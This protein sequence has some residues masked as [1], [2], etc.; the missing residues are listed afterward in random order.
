MSLTIGVDVGGTKI[1][2]GVVTEDGTLLEEQRRDTPA[3]D[4]PATEEAIAD[5]VRDLCSRHTAEAV[6]IAAAG[7]VDAERSSVLFAPNLAWRDEPLREAV[8]GLTDLP[9]VVE[10]D[11]NAAA[12]GEF[13]FGAAADVE[14]SLMVAL[15]TGIGGAI[16]IDGDLFR[17]T[18][19]VAGEFGHMRVVPDG[20]LCG[21][22]NHGCW[23]QYASGKAMTRAAREA[24]AEGLPQ[25]AELIARAGGDPDKITGQLIMEAARD[26][27]GFAL[28]AFG[29]L[30]RWLGEGLADLAA[31]F[32][33]GVIVL[34]GGVSEAGNL[35]LE[36]TR[37]A[38][39]RQLPGRGHRPEAELRLAQLGNKAGMVGVADL[40]RHRP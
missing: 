22:G 38:F 17:G 11:A 36:P 13:R 14:D 9:V 20:H 24:A 40:A 3:L 12:W 28:A 23:E 1:A 16:V 21:C 8:E 5:A 4:A 29:T 39:L 32:D 6:G 34:G 35:L 37:A 30:A 15:G 7:Y 10:N 19:G 31:A 25:A 33:P 2:A 18:F 26:G 27:E